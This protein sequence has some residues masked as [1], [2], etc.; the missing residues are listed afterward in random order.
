MGFK[1]NQHP[2]RVGRI[3][4]NM[5]TYSKNSIAAICLFLFAFLQA[6]HAEATRSTPE[7]CLAPAEPS[8]SAPAKLRINGEPL[9]S[10]LTS[11]I[12]TDA[13][14]MEIELSGASPEAPL[15]ITLANPKDRGYLIQLSDTSWSY[16]PG[17][18]RSRP[19]SSF[20]ERT[21]LIDICQGEKHTRVQILPTEFTPELSDRYP[22]SY[23]SPLPHRYET[24]SDFIQVNSA[25]E[26]AFQISP[27]F[28]LGQF[29]PKQNGKR[30]W[31]QQAL[32]RMP[33]LEKLERVMT[34]LSENDKAAKTLTIL[35]GYRLPNHNGRV[36]GARYSRH[37]YGDAADFIVDGN[38]D[39]KMD[40]L[41]R[42][43]RVNRSDL[44]W[45]LKRLKR[46][47]TP[48]T[49]GGTGSYESHGKA[50][51]FLHLD[52]RGKAFYW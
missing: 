36:G 16:W 48:I 32:I 50:K 18:S 39:G 26:A 28:T 31:P 8:L 33:L 15:R 10:S 17:F 46:G 43:G 3:I 5:H 38:G 37:M 30:T 19:G 25:A 51:A 49:A 29:L 45:L 20:S 21:R 52:A 34:V 14:P 41:N 44:N 7:A 13:K 12:D 2:S 27:H 9:S 35:S 47:S 6:E 1:S 4:G 11:L 22:P 40:D 24:P 23:E 42:D